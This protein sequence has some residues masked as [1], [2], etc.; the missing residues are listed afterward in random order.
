MG[1]EEVERL[2]DL[3]DDDAGALHVRHG[4][5]D[6]ARPVEDVGGA[7][8]RDERDAD[9]EREQD[10]QQEAGEE[11]GRDAEVEDGHGRPAGQHPPPEIC[12]HD[13]QEQPQ[14]P[15]PVQAG[16]LPAD[17]DIRNG[18]TQD[19]RLRQLLNVHAA[20]SVVGPKARLPTPSRKRKHADLPLRS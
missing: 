8:G 11:L 3:F 17:H 10:D 4:D 5:V 12:G 7:A 9:H 15:Q 14:P 20:L 19:V 18:P 16:P 1:E 2:H 13:D 6:L